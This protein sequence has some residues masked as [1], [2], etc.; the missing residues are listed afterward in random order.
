MNSPLYTI[1]ATAV[2]GL[3]AISY[4]A[5]ADNE[6]VSQDS[7]TTLRLLVQSDQLRHPTTLRV[8][9]RI[10]N[11][12]L[13]LIEAPGLYGLSLPPTGHRYAIVAD[14]LVRIDPKDGQVLSILREIDPARE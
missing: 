3:S 7:T 4:T 9:D 11:A 13:Q 12:H 14:H 5:V 1:A 2:L 6:P 10:D 8:G